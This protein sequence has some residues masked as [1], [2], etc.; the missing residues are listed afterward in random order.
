MEEGEKNCEGQAGFR[1]NRGC[2]D[3]IYTLGKVIQGRV[4]A[5]LTAYCFVLDVRKAYDTVWRNGLW[6]FFGGKF[7]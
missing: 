5:G 2:V 6:K 4:D 7:V 1:R 3:H